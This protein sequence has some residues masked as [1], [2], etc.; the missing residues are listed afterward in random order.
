M[1]RIGALFG[2]LGVHLGGLGAPRALFWPLGAPREIQD[3]IVEV[4]FRLRAHFGSPRGAKESPRQ[5]QRGQHDAQ[6]DPREPKS[7]C[8][9]AQDRPQD[10]PNHEKPIFTILMPL[11]SEICVFRVLGVPNWRPVGPSRLQVV[12]KLA[13][14]GPSR[15]QDGPRPPQ[16]APRR[17]QDAPKTPK[18]AQTPQ[19]GPGTKRK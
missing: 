3:L 11:C 2:P 19:N 4:F 1:F 12:P 13:Q 17:V 5:P 9:G 10:P 18:T 14:V 16:D 7:L 8:R 15:F 6:S